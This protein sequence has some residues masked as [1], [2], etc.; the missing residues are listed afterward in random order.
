MC[1]CEYSC[2]LW[3]VYVCTVAYCNVYVSVQ[4]HIG[5]CMCQYR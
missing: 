2:T 4:L 1:M 3:C 5:I